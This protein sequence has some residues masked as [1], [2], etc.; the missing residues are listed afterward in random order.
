MEAGKIQ[1]RVGAPWGMIRPFESME[2]KNERRMRCD[3]NR[4]ETLN[5]YGMAIIVSRGRWVLVG[6]VQRLVQIC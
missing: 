3:V 2:E 4:D 6:K 5:L 1:G